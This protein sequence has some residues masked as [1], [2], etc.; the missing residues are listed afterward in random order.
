MT[1][2]PTLEEIAVVAKM[3]VNEVGT[4]KCSEEQRNDG[5]WLIGFGVE[6]PEALRG[7]ALEPVN[8][9]YSCETLGGQESPLK[10][11]VDVSASVMPPALAVFV[12]AASP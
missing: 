3:T 5:S 8:C 12:P 9:G 6:T 2:K 7:G 1:S 11:D 10:T 4:Y